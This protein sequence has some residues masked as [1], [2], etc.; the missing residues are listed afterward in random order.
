MISL[1]RLLKPEQK[2]RTHKEVIQA[3]KIMMFFYITAK[4]TTYVQSKKYVLL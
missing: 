4:I 1:H 2:N 3:S